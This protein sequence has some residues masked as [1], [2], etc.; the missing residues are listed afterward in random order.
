MPL[1]LNVLS[2]RPNA[3]GI[4]TRISTAA[5]GSQ[6]NGYSY[7]AQATADGH[8][9]MFLSNASNLSAEAAFDHTKVIRKNLVTSGVE[10]ISASFDG[11]IS[12][13]RT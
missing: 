2:V 7:G 9:A 3:D 8:Y 5:D 10:L 1:T 13:S 12:S 11:A 6:A 4:I